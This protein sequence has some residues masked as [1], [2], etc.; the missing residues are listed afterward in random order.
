MNNSLRKRKK[1][2]GREEGKE[3]GGKVSERGNVEGRRG[4]NGRQKG[5]EG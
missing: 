1:K 5:G 4:M 2:R 3:K